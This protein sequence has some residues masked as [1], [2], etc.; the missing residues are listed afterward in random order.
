MGWWSKLQPRPPVGVAAR[1]VL[2]VSGLVASGIC[3]QQDEAAAIDP[4]ILYGPHGYSTFSHARC[5]E[6]PTV[7]V[8]LS[9]V[10]RESSTTTVPRARTAYWRGLLPPSS[11]SLDETPFNWFFCPIYY[12]TR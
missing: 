9:E 6:V 1:L 2:V 10:E 3:Q 7:N 8:S 12:Y 4:Y 5:Q 11:T